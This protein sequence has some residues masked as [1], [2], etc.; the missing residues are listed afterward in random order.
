MTRSFKSAYYVSTLNETFALPL[1]DNLERTDAT[2]IR[3]AQAGTLLTSDIPYYI[4]GTQH[5]PN[6]SHCGAYRHNLY[7]FWVSAA[8]PPFLKKHL[9]SVPPN[10]RSQQ[11]HKLTSAPF[12]LHTPSTFRKLSQTTTWHPH[13][14]K[15]SDSDSIISV[16][17]L[18]LSLINKKILPIA[19]KLRRIKKA[20]SFLNSDTPL[21]WVIHIMSEAAIECS[22]TVG[23]LPENITVCFGIYVHRGKALDWTIRLLDS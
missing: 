12:G 15:K 11:H 2:L 21:V 9:S 4:S 14:P 17:P 18:S 7:E 19:A 3:L 13:K 1:N 16:P 10:I 8:A 6:C 23:E 5:T 22:S 20:L